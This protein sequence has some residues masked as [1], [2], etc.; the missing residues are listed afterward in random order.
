LLAGLLLVGG[1]LAQ[2]EG[3]IRYASNASD[4]GARELD[5]ARVAAFEAA[6][7]DQPVEH[8]V[9]DHEAFKQAIR[10]FLVADPAPDVLTWFAGNRMTF[11][12]DR[13]LAADIS[14]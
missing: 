4:E 1:V 10:A 5:E 8:S 13:G 9:T 14:E 11:F 3:L 6:N 12:V 7:P 2:E